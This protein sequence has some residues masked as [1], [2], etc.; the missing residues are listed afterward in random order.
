[1]KMVLLMMKLLFR[2]FGSGQDFFGSKGGCISYPRAG[3]AT[4][5]SEDAVLGLLVGVHVAQS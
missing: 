5:V 4:A 3:Y 2:N 1:M